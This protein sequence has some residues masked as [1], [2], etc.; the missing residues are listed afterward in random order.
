MFWY[1][2]NT[3]RWLN[4]ALAGVGYTG[5]ALL[6]GFI[7]LSIVM[8]DAALY[9]LMLALTI[10]AVPAAMWWAWG[11]GYRPT[12]PKLPKWSGAMRMVF[13]RPRYARQYGNTTT[14][15]WTLEEV[16]D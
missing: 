6:V 3:P 1:Y 16:D 9:G 11:S 14:A 4:N 13:P 10:I 5:I 7:L 8:Y 15:G 2:K 12:L